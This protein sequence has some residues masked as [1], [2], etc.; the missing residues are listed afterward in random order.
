MQR[1]FLINGLPVSAQ[2][3]EGVVDHI[4][5][6]LLL[7]WQK[8][9]REKGDRLIILL[10]A[11][12]GTGKSTLAAFLQQLAEETGFTITGHS[13]EVQGECKACREKAEGR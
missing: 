1:T 5:R 9:Q 3:D 8:M 11:P 6:P 13:F 10:A 12:P 7:H 2:F 4:L